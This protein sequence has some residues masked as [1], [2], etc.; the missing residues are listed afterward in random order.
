M[1]SN[2]HG[3]SSWLRFR[4][5]ASRWRK[6]RI[7]VGLAVIVAS[8][9]FV[10][11]ANASHTEIKSTDETFNSIGDD[12]LH[13]VYLSSPRHL[14][15]GDRGELGWEENING[16]HWNRY[17]ATGNYKNGSVST[18]WT[19]NIRSR[20]FQVVV[21]ANSRDDGY[22]QNRTA[23]NNWGAD[24]HLVTHTNAGGGDYM[25]IMVDDDTSTSLDT[26]LQG[27]ID[28]RLGDYVPGAEVLTTDDSPYVGDLAELTANADYNVYVELIFHDNQSHVDWLGSG[29]DW[30]SSVTHHAWRYG[31]AIDVA[32]GYP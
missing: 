31:Y 24:V 6:H 10:P 25:L 2:G 30:A 23:S 22:M 12:N 21:S 18:S 4:E 9:V 11:Q 16:R 27:Q 14:S 32:L 19:R 7:T 8:V 26:G 3:R 1:E 17:A 13:K 20:G 15:S 28:I 5:R 29:D